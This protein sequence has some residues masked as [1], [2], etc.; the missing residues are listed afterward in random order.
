M[1]DL[2]VSTAAT[3]GGAGTEGDPYTLTEARTNVTAGDIVY[4]LAGTYTDEDAS[5]GAVLDINVVGTNVAWIMWIG[6]TTTINDFVPGTTPPVILDAGTNTL[7][8]GANCTT[9]GGSGYNFFSGFEFSGGSGNGFDCGS[10]VDNIVCFGCSFENNGARGAQGDNN[11]YFIACLFT[12]NTTNSFDCDNTCVVAYN[13]FHNEPTNTVTIGSGACIIGNLAYNNGDGIVF[14]VNSSTPNFLENSIDGEGQTNAIGL[15]ITGSSNLMG[16]VLNNIFFDLGTAVNFANA[17]VEI[18]YARGFNLFQS[19]TTDYDVLS[20]AN[21]DVAG[22][23]DPYKDST[24]RDYRLKDAGE[25]V[26]TGIG[27]INPNDT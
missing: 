13:V 20:L 11:M 16:T 24:A 2:Y 26:D 21:T 22:T 3:G 5:S 19:N 4:V 23:E 1:A 14:A 17:G 18:I 12:G 10:S 7:T 15:S 6:Y 25:A 8:N 9:L 27:A